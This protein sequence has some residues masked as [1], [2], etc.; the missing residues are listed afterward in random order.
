MTQRLAKFGVVGI[1]ATMSYYLVALLLSQF[2][3]VFWANVVGYAGGMCVSYLGHHRLTFAA[4]K[5]VVP[6][7]QAISRFAAGSGFAFIMS[8]IILY[9]AVKLLQL[10][11]WL[12]LGLVVITVPLITFLLYQFWVFAPSD[13]EGSLT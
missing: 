5:D 13:K 11:D 6:H 3:G 2:V 12:G 4:T 7:G 9:A 1:V 8:Q 10:P